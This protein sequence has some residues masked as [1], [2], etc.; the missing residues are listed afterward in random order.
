MAAMDD[1]ELFE[2]STSGGHTIR[3]RNKSRDWTI[4]ASVKFRGAC[5]EPVCTV[6]IKP[7]GEVEVSR[8]Y[9]TR[10]HCEIKSASY[11]D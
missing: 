8:H 10:C 1:V 11:A 6:T 5:P 4:Q 7:L 3:I 9:S 2:E